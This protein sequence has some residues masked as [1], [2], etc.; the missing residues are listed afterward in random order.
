MSTGKRSAVPLLLSSFPVPPTHIPSTPL[1]ARLPSPLPSPNP[2][3]SGP[4]LS[5]LPPVPGPSPI[6]EHDT[7][8][9][10]SAERSRRASKMSMASTA[11][12]YSRRDSVAT[13]ASLSSSNP[14]P[15]SPTTSYYESASTRSI[16]SLSSVGSA[17]HPHA[18]YVFDKSPM[19]EPRICEEEP[20]ELSQM[21]LTEITPPHLSDV[22]PSPS[23]NGLSDSEA[24]GILDLGIGSSI[25]RG[26]RGN[27]AHG[28][29]DSIASIDINDLPALQEDETE[30]LSAPPI[31]PSP[32][33]P[34][35]LR[36][37]ILNRPRP[38]TAVLYKDLPP[39]P[40]SAPP[41][42]SSSSLRRSGSVSTTHTAYARDGAESPDI[43]T[44]IATTPRPRRKS[45]S[46]F[47][48]GS[49]S[50]SRPNSTRRSRGSSVHRSGTGSR[51]T[52]DAVAVPVPPLRFSGDVGYSE[53]AYTRREHDEDE[54]SDYGELIDGTG[55][56]MDSRMLSHEAEARLERAL[57]GFDTEDDLDAVSDGNASDSSID[58]Q[59]PLP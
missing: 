5:P 32:S 28:M 40:H 29:N 6:S 37:V 59:T 21:S 8:R 31:L 24:E 50:R 26:H 46:Q 45:S 38:P 53:L 22:P 51:R 52:S 49:R 1:S 18:R 10:I 2:P 13:E 56:T 36:P 12:M 30:L 17:A 43:A 4:P 3:L 23:M 48:N 58:V 34:P 9:F 47:S 57:E 42:A 44:I 39:L 7:L 54:D 33:K 20:A 25:S 35:H 55:T 14:P 11:S 15:L 19:F 27:R 16:R 41:E